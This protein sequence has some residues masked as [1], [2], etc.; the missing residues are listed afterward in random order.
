MMNVFASTAFWTYLHALIS[1][2]LDLFSSPSGITFVR[3]ADNV[4]SETILGR[5]QES[6]RY[7]V[8]KLVRIKFHLRKNCENGTVHAEFLFEVTVLQ[9]L[10]S[11]RVSRAPQHL[12][13]YRHALSKLLMDLIIIYEFSMLTR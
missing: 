13:R 12:P 5:Y 11:S 7:G 6:Q 1:I 3:D 4:V 9:R 10:S 2:C 8:P